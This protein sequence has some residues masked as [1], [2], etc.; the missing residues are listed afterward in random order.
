MNGRKWSFLDRKLFFGLSHKL[1]YGSS[2]S[3][4]SDP[5]PDL[6]LDISIFLKV[7]AIQLVLIYFDQI[8]FIAR[9]SQVFEMNK[10]FILLY[11]DP[12]FVGSGPT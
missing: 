5:D 10:F 4:E 3:K 6:V 11:M 7:L 12:V 9:I 2:Y 1:G 8:R